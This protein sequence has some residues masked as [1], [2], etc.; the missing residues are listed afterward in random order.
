MS[1]SNNSS[2]F[3]TSRPP[4]VM[5]PKWWFYVSRAFKWCII[6]RNPTGGLKVTSVWSY[7]VLSEIYYPINRTGLSDW[8]DSARMHLTETCFLPDRSDS[9]PDRSNSELSQLTETETLSDRSGRVFG[10][11]ALHWN[12][13][14]GCSAPLPLQAIAWKTYR[15][16]ATML[17]HSSQSSFPCIIVD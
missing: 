10:R 1:W 15:K 3:I 11:S 4:I 6:R 7:Q 9:L 14:F 5:K 13:A 16:W 12:P 8:S 2:I 17:S